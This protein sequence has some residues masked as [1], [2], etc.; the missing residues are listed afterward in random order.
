MSSCPCNSKKQFSECCEPVI[1]GTLKAPTADALMR[2]RYTAYATGAIDHIYNSY[3]PAKRHD[4]DKKS[5]AEWS[6]KSKWL[7]LEILRTEKGGESDEDG[8]VEFVAKYEID[9][10]PQE[11]HELAEFRKDGNDGNWYFVDG[12]SPKVATYV[13]EEP[14]T[15]RN[16][17]CT[18]GSGKKYKKCCGIRA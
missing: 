10:Q 1:K 13:R 5:A 6:R 12:R 15:G 7:G 11:H 17:P 8:T 14:K 18:C 9:D 16:D 3:D 4:F 2:S